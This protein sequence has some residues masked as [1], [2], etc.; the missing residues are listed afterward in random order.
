MEVHMRVLYLILCCAVLSLLSGT[1]HAGKVAPLARY[2]SL[3]PDGK[4][5][6]FACQGDIWKVATSGGVAR[7][8]TDHVAYEAF[9]KFSRDGKWIA[10]ASARWGNYDVYIIP[11]NG[12][13]ARRLTFHEYSDYPECWSPDS[14]YVYFRSSRYGSYDLYRI[15]IEGGTPVRLTNSYWDSEYYFSISPNGKKIAFC[16]RGGSSGYHRKLYKGSSNADIWTANLENPLTGFKRITY[17]DVNEYWPFWT[18]DG[19]SL[20]YV[21]H[22]SGCPN[23]WRKSAEAGRGEQLT[24]YTDTGV[25]FPT[26]SADGSIIVFEH[27]FFLYSYKPGREP[28][29]INIEAPSDTKYNEIGIEKITS[30]LQEYSL[31]PDG[32]K[33]AFILRGDVWL[34]PAEEGGEARRL[35]ETNGEHW[36]L[37]WAPDSER[38]SYTR[39]SGDNL[40]VY[41]NVIPESREYGLAVSEKLEGAARWSP[42]GKSIVY[43]ADDKELWITDPEGKEHRKLVE[44]G[45]IRF[46]KRAGENYNF[47]PDSKWLAYRETDDNFRAFIHVIPV[48][49]GEK[50]R[51]TEFPSCYLPRWSKDGKLLYFLADEQDNYNVYKLPLQHEEIEFTEDKLDK[52]FE[53]KK[54]EPK[55]T[56]PAK[57]EGEAPEEPGKPEEKGN[58]EPAVKKKSMQDEKKPEKKPEKKKVEVK[59]DLRDIEKRIER[60]TS[61]KASEGSAL[62]TPDGKTWVFT[63]D[64]YKGRQIW[65]LSAEKDKP[66]KLRQLTTSKSRISNLQLDPNGKSVYFESGGRISQLNLSS[67]KTKQIPFNAEMRYDQRKLRNHVFAQAHWLIKTQF[68]DEKLHGANW[69]EAYARYKKVLP[70]ISTHQQFDDLLE[71]MLGELNASHLGYYPKAREKYPVSISTGWL[72]IDF[73]QEELEEGRFKI[74]R[75]LKGTPAD[76]PHSKLEV[77]EYIVKLNNA[78][79]GSNSNIFYALEETTG[80]R[81]TLTVAKDLSSDSKRTVRIKP[82]TY[83][84]I[85]RA[86]YYEWVDSMREQVHK[87]SENRLGY[88]HVPAMSSRTLDKFARE[89]ASEAADKLGLVIDVRYNGGGSTAVHMLE[90]LYR[91]PWLI[92]G[93]RDFDAKISENLYRSTAFEKPTIALINERSFSNAEVFAEGYSR[94]GLGKLVGVP[95]AGGCIG[96]SSVRLVDGSSMRLPVVGAWTVEGE[97]LDLC[98]RAPDVKVDNSPNDVAQGVDMQLQKAVELLLKQVQNK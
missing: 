60:V 53:K 25:Y 24:H 94:L 98:G 18:K 12:G 88:V 7:R 82:A 70:R 17:S 96:T 66:E 72:G 74:A 75:V 48:A 10:F 32:K 5:I 44:G 64:L 45:F 90:M 83:R 39:R 79:L 9:P 34:I 40:D 49:G 14:K 30:G 46:T 58:G 85:S 57:K 67:A 95:T 2:P 11:S 71:F 15:S 92:R 84:D 27:N 52:L 38:I 16:R 63:S 87:L 78:E 3:S 8:L 61:T 77:G 89:L 31:S 68:Y 86:R 62:L 55:K 6:A 93:Y 56:A 43:C 4:E 42:D 21:S 37:E 73:D 36:S 13:K 23:L 50:K 54:E 80:K 28:A 19:R 29:R 26:I 20:Y 65:T 47:S 22:M 33:I 76:N 69:S 97:N 59:I 35:T 51:V 41:V 91:K 1:V 81:I